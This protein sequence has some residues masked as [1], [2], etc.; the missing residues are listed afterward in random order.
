M[1]YELDRIGN[2]F[3]PPSYNTTWAG[4][5]IGVRSDR[6]MRPSTRTWSPIWDEGQQATPQSLVSSRLHRK[7]D[8]IAYAVEF[9]LRLFVE[10]ILKQSPQRC[11]GGGTTLLYHALSAVLPSEL[12]LP[13]SSEPHAMVAL[14][15]AAH[16]DINVSIPAWSGATLWRV[17]LHSISAA[18]TQ[19]TALEETATL[20]QDDSRC[21]P[22]LRH[23]KTIRW[24]FSDLNNICE[25]LCRDST[26]KPLQAGSALPWKD[27]T[28]LEL[29]L[30]HGADPREMDKR[31]LSA[32]LKQCCVP[33][34]NR[35]GGLTHIGNESRESI[36]WSHHI[37]VFEEL[38]EMEF[39]LELGDE[40]PDSL[41]W[42]QTH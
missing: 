2:A 38:D 8:L 4:Q 31:V 12:G 17:F 30:H 34:R 23:D 36:M 13:S 22:V 14:L 37:G 9:D 29:M 42:T 26:T 16:A 10:D 15:F 33:C 21:S 6:G 32:L 7:R 25:N 5:R 39:D 20:P 18:K 41:G 35:Y 27:T 1:I 28:L 11:L 19:I 3:A 40:M 24:H